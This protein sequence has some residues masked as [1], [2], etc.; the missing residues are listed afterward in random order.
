[1]KK[2][3]IL[4]VGIGTIIYFLYSYAIPEKTLITRNGNL[5]F[6]NSPSAIIVKNHLYIAY[7]SNN[8]EI[9]VKKYFKIGKIVSFIQ[10]YIIHNHSKRSNKNHGK[11]IDD[12]SAPAIVYDK[13]KDQILLA[14]A[15]HGTNLHLYQFNIKHNKWHSLKTFKGKCTYPRFMSRN[16][17]IYILYRLQYTN[18]H[19]GDLVMR[20]SV[21]DFIKEDTIIKAQNETVIYASSPFI[22]KDSFFITYSTHSYSENRLKGWKILKVNFS[23]ITI[24]K[25]IDLEKY[26]DKNYFSNRPTAIYTNEK[27]IFIGTALYYHEWK[28]TPNYS[29][30]NK[31]L[32][33]Q[34]D[35]TTNNITILHTNSIHFPYYAT[36]IS[37]DKEG[38][39]IYFDKNKIMSS[40]NDIS[41]CITNKN[42]MYPY[43]FENNLLYAYQN[44]SYSIRDFNNSIFLCTDL[45]SN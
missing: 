33:I 18:T 7:V 24:K 37:F 3:I 27:F 11:S 8:G 16:H 31:I 44:S 36:S 29:N 45:K 39:Y 15:Y 21:D 32:I 12:H 28:D 4:I 20:S 1:M 22:Y 35:K 5:L 43:L 34:I 40:I 10:D 23:D 2:F 41:S 26:L 38:N 42:M 30:L 6:Y 19:S 17:N 13:K 25:E 9:H 14:T